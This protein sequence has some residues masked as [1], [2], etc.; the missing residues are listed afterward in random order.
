MVHKFDDAYRWHKIR[1]DPRPI[2]FLK[3]R[4]S[5]CV[6]AAARFLHRKGSCEH[7]WSLQDQEGTIIALLI[8]SK[9][10]L[11]PVFNGKKDLSFPCFLSHFLR[12]VAIHSV[13]GLR[14]DA[15]LLESAIALLGIIPAEQIDYDLMTLDREPNPDSFRAGPQRLILR[16]PIPSDMEDLFLLQ[17]AYEQEEV[18][19]RGAEFNPATCRL[20][21]EHIVAHE[22]ILIA[23]LEGR[24]LGKINTNAA[25]FSRYQLG[26]LYVRPEYRGLGIASQMIAV[27]VQNILASGKGVTLFVKKQNRAA[28]RVYRRVGFHIIEDYRIS[29]Y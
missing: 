7:G 20:V 13:Q 15:E 24:I 26:G 10:S 19:P 6:A 11:F 1:T 18:L 9:R 27:F 5:Y 29:Y 16:R 2:E 3:A 12:K 17:A 14:K 21:L 25:S 4:E 22:Q 28:S 8:H 23:E